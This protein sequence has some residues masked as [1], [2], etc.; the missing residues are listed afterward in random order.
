MISYEDA[1]VSARKHIEALPP[2]E[3][4]V[5]VL[6]EGTRVASGWYFDYAF[7]ALPG[8]ELPIVGGAPGFL[9]MDDG[10][11]RV[12]AWGKDLR[13]LKVYEEEA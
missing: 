9:V 4:C 13:S 6:R 12:V 7:E 11:V 5:W 3:D 1:L 2:D 10:S 8:K